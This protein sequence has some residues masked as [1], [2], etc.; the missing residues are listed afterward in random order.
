MTYL[1]FGKAFDDIVSADGVL[2]KVKAGAKLVGMSA[3]IVTDAGLL[4][5]EQSLQ[6]GLHRSDL[7]PETRDR[8]ESSY[9]DAK[10]AR[11]YFKN[12]ELEFALK[13]AQAHVDTPDLTDDERTAALSNVR[14]IEDEMRRLEQ[15]D[16]DD[17]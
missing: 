13:D 17:E 3:F 14:S 4:A 8:L 16:A 2:D 15:Q 10:R 12:K 9:A 5:V 1:D 11:R 7:D 6:E